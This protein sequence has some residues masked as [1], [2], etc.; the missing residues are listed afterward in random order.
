MPSSPRHD[1]T[2][3]F[4]YDELLRL[5]HRLVPSGSHIGTDRFALL[6]IDFLLDFYLAL[7]NISLL[8]QNLDANIQNTSNNLSELLRLWHRL[9]PSR[10][11]IGTDRFA[12]LLIDFLLDFYLALWNISL[13]LAKSRC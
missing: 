8:W 7:W 9:V 3:A 4:A 11:H 6:L 10:S 12:L 2:S 1:A 5:W 13:L